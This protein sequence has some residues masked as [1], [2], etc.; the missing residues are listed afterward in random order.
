MK[1][2]K[3]IGR[4]VLS[5]LY[6][7]LL[8]LFVLLT[9]TVFGLHAAND[10]DTMEEVKALPEAEFDS[11]Y[12]QEYPC[13]FLECMMSS[14]N[15][16]VVFSE[17]GH[18]FLGRVKYFLLVGVL[19]LIGLVSVHSSSGVS[20]LLKLGNVGIAMGIYMYLIPQAVE[21]NAYFKGDIFVQHFMEPLYLPLMI[22]FILG[23]I[24]VVGALVWKY[25]SA[26]DRD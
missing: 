26:P 10:Y 8:G 18:N 23:V 17:Q 12:Y 2:V 9:V 25:I 24:A 6:A 11:Y 16:E 5:G 22:A 20:A 1:W 19:I 4:K 15:R 3:N 14:E 7:G 21:S 13:T